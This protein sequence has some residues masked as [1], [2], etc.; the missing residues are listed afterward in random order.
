M[1]LN[2]I[3]SQVAKSFESFNGSIKTV[4]VDNT[5]NKNIFDV[6]QNFFQ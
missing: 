5:K 4:F 6:R 3:C 2:I 1:K